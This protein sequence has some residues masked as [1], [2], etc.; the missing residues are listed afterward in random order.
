MNV[1][2][3]LMSAQGPPLRWDAQKEAVD[4][5]FDRR[6]HQSQRALGHLVQPIAPSSPHAMNVR[7]TP[8]TTEHARSDGSERGLTERSLAEHS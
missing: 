6:G 8:E 2:A 4:T 5:Q 3:A 7:A 1:A